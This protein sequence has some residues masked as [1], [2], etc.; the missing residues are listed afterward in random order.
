VVPPAVAVVV[1]VAVA[2]S[3]VITTRVRREIITNQAFF[4]ELLLEVCEGS[5]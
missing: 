2:V 3:A 5:T 4:L 1:A